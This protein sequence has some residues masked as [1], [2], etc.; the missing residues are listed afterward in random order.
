MIRCL[1]IVCAC[2]LLLTANA[3]IYQSQGKDGSTVYS[4]SPQGGQSQPVR[5]EPL[6]VS[7]RPG[8]T[9]ELTPDMLKLKPET[10]SDKQQ[11]K[12]VSIKVIKPTDGETLWNQPKIAVESDI[13]PGLPESSKVQ[14]WVDGRLFAS[15]TDGQF[16]IENMD[17]GIHTLQVR[18]VSADN[19]RLAESNSVK[20][21]VHHTFK[22][23]FKVVRPQGAR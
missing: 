4:D 6:S 3:A 10:S 1:S 8:S 2:L 7:S 19:K 11:V 5:L 22:T 13:S 20:I 21:Y 17:R 18:V 14:L 16:V 15:N 9:P 23:Q 12:T